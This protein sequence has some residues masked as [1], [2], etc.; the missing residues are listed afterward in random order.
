MDLVACMEETIVSFP[1][2]I[3]RLIQKYC[4][5]TLEDMKKI[6]KFLVPANLKFQ[7]RNDPFFNEIEIRSWKTDV[8]H[9]TLTFY[10]WQPK[11]AIYGPKRGTTYLSHAHSDF[12]FGTKIG[13]SWSCILDLNSISRR[14][15]RFDSRHKG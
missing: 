10:F 4:F 15:D 3:I 9:E 5:L 6:E 7:V 11:R 12:T 13:V 8:D 1:F 14:K 2:E